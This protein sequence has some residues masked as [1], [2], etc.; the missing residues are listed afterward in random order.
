MEAKMYIYIYVQGYA[1]GRS[2]SAAGEGLG[3]FSYVPSWWRVILNYTAV[4]R[5][6]L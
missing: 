5:T 3:F 1:W 2:A 4:P 6:F